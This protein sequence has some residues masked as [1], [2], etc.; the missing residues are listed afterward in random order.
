MN[1]SNSEVKFRK[2]PSLKFLYE[3]SEDGRIVRNVKSKHHLRQEQDWGGY[4]RVSPF[5]NGKQIHKF[6]HILVAECWLGEK[7]DE[8]ECD[9]IDNNRHNNH[10]TNLRYVTKAENLEKR[11]F[12]EEGKHRNGEITRARYNAMS[13]EQKKICVDKMLKGHTP[14][15]EEHRINAVMTALA[16]PV[17][18]EKDGVSLRFESKAKCCH[19]I[20]EKDGCSV[21][22]IYYYIKQKRQYIHGYRITYEK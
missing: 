22:A 18:I 7:P 20:A 12:T 2:I 13:S 11:V 1:K 8:L 10:Y 21:G 15:V 9:H 14:E 19:Y 17:I 16:H 3:V 4:Y 6:V 5:I